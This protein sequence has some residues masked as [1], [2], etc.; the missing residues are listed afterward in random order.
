MNVC[1][2]GW[3]LRLWSRSCLHYR[4]GRN[5]TAEAQEAS[6]DMRDFP[7]AT[8]WSAATARR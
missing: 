6:P 1:N 3:H 7:G 2:A 8:A 4:R 5:G